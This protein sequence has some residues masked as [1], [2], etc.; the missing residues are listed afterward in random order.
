MVIQRMHLHGNEIYLRFVIFMASIERF[1]ETKVPSC[2]TDWRAAALRIVR[3]IL[4]FF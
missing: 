3:D 2:G 1:Y 4:I